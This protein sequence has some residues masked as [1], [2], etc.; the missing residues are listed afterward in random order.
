MPSVSL[1]GRLAS[2]ALTNGRATAPDPW[3]TPEGRGGTTKEK[4]PSTTDGA[5]AMI[6]SLGLGEGADQGHSKF[7]SISLL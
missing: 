2:L 3:G 1:R 6:G 5:L 7:H 4:A